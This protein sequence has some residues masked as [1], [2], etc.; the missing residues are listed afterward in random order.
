MEF[1]R[2]EFKKKYP[3]IAR[4]MEEL[5]ELKESK[6]EAEGA[7]KDAPAS[8]QPNVIDFLRRCDTEAQG[9][10]IIEYMLKRGEIDEKYAEKLKSQMSK[11]GIRSFGAKKE[12]GYYTK[13]ALQI[14][15]DSSSDTL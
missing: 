11:K 5:G 13:A 7:K 2:D 9:L 1:S 12:K 8:Y 15:E 3:N 14:A 10:E 4:E 6:T